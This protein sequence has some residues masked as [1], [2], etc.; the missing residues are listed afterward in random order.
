M[1]V[2]HRYRGLV[3]YDGTDFLGYQIQAR[4]RTVQAE[5]EQALKKVTQQ[6]IRIDAAGR[7]DAG[8]HAT[9]QVVAFNA[10]WK[11]HLHDLHRAL[12]ATLPPDIVFSDL[13]ITHRAFHPRFNALSRTYHYTVINRPWPSVL[14]RRYA[15]HVKKN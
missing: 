5:I 9:G 4:G 3:E 14:E 1:S 7:T 15:C 6:T 10:V 11:H 13:K 12:N 2:E 8:V